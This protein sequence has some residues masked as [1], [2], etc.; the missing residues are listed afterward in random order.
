MTILED[1]RIEYIMKKELTCIKRDG[2]WFDS[3][4]QYKGAALVKEAII[5]DEVDTDRFIEYINKNRLDKVIIDLF[6]SG[7][8]SLE[9]VKKIKSVKYLSLWGNGKVDNSPLY[10]LENIKFLNLVNHKP[11]DVS[12]FKRLEFLSSNTFENI[13]NLDKSE[14]LKALSIGSAMNRFKSTDLSFVSNL[15]DLAVIDIAD[16]NLHSLEGLERLENIKFIS[17]TNLKSLR[18]LDVFELNKLN[19]TGLK[20][21]NCKNINDLSKIGFLDKLQYLSLAKMGKIETISFLKK[22][23]CIENVV[24]VETMVNDNDL[25]ALLKCNDVALY[26]LK[27]E[28]FI[29]DKN[30]EKKTDFKSRTS[31][32]LNYGN[33]SVPEWLRIDN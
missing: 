5:I 9:F 29:R 22:C 14:N 7:I 17:L 6:N 11:I 3:I 16:I 18:S 30:T 32:Y 13:I 10:E 15:S 23:L 24:I 8:Q 1:K 12:K 4:F 25:T 31:E 19:V 28:Y 20:I 26:P 2:F 27:R 21:Y 33:D